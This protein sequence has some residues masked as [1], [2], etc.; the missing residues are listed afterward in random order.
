MQSILM[1]QLA[2]GVLRRNPTYL[3][4]NDEP[5]Q[6]FDEHGL[7]KGWVLFPFNFDPTWLNK[8]L[9]YEDT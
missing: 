8:C 6:D 9:L 5:A 2:Q 7:R 3:L 1:L 4:I